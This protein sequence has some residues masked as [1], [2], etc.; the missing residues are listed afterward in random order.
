MRKFWDWLTVGSCY[1]Y[2]K[3]G[4]KLGNQLQY[5]CDRKK[6]IPKTHTCKPGKPMEA[7]ADSAMKYGE[8]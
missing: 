2:Q 7:R 3:L 6:Y 1:V 4:S 5:E 8:S